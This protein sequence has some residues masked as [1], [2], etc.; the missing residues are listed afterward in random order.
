MSNDCVGILSI[1]KSGLLQELSKAIREL[2]SSAFTFIFM[3]ILMRLLIASAA[4]S[5]C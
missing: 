2:I 3:V 4:W 5:I 1:A